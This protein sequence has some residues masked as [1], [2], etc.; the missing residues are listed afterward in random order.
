MISTALSVVNTVL[1]FLSTVATKLGLDLLFV[2][3]LGVEILF[4]LFFI[5][6]SS[7]SY[8]VSLNRALDKL[9]YWL[10]QKKVVN[11]ENIRS[12]NALFKTRAPK[13][14]TYYW[15]QYV[16]F[17]EG[18]PSTYFTADN[19]VDKPVKTSSYA[20]DIK[21]LGIVTCV[22]AVLAT[23]FVLISQSIEASTITGS[24]LVTALLL[25]FVIVLLG[26]IFVLYMR[27]RRNNVIA[28]VYQNVS[29][30]DRFMDNACQDLTAYVDYQI[31]FTPA[32]IQK[33][34][35]VL[36][37]FLDFKAR[38]E[39]EEFS[40]AKE[41]QI[42]HVKYDF[43]KTGVNGKIVLDRAMKETE[44]FLKRRDKLLV[45]IAQLEAELD[46][47][48]KN[49]DNVQIESQTKIQ[50]S[51]E[52]IVRLRQM[53]E[54]T[55]NRIESNYYRKQQTQEAA[56]QEQLEQE[57]E[58]QKAKYLLEKG[59]V[60][61]E[62][63]A[64]KGDL[65]N[66][67]KSVEDAMLAEYTTFFD[68]FCTSAEKVVGKV[69]EEKFHELKQENE[70]DKE[71]ITELELQLKNA[72]QPSPNAQEGTYDENGNYV[73]PNGTYYD[74]DGLF[75]DVQDGT[76]VTSTA[77][78]HYD[79]AGNYI[80][81]N[82]TYYDKSGFFHDTQGNVYSQD[83]KLVIA[84]QKEEVPEQTIDL[85]DFDSFDFMT[86]VGQKEDVYDVAKDI[87]NGLGEGVTVTNSAK[88][89]EEPAEEPAEESKEEKEEVKPVEEEKPQEDKLETVSLDDIE[90]EN[91]I[92]LDDFEKTDFG[93]PEEEQ[94]EEEPEEIE[95][96]EEEPEDEEEEE[97]DFEYEEEKP[98]KRVG[99]PR[100]I[101]SA[102][103]K[104]KKP[105]RPRK[106]K[107]AAPA[108]K[109][110]V[111]RP[112]KVEVAEPPKKRVGRPRKVEAAKVAKKPVGRPK[113]AVAEQ[114]RKVG[115]PRKTEAPK[116]TK[117]PVGRPRKTEVLPEPK[118]G[119][120]RPRKTDSISEINRRLSEEE[121][122]LAQMRRDLNRELELAMNTNGVDAVQSKRN[123]L[124]KEIDKLQREAQNA[125]NGN[126]SE[127]K[128]K[129]IN[130]KLEKILAEI[131]RLG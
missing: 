6:K 39:K 85:N 120:G 114:K 99:R 87:I 117:K 119:R 65:E 92:S 38:K 112:R 37:E 93:E 30:F 72:S 33:G 23:V 111:G 24:A 42:D 21:N 116:V 58:Q 67:R 60:E 123:K 28:A 57:F 81:P 83:G 36:R 97:D 40:R 14:L 53:Q 69:F 70:T 127:E 118:K 90:K 108:K 8:E 103:A 2:I 44:L 128:M 113:K 122:K 101:V 102:P 76:L 80:Y 22:W 25:G 3:G 73:Y 18:K 1:N 17:R 46:S 129:Q 56:K 74:K 4:I 107:P 19:L 7:S 12:L 62:I 47:R 95:E 100:K 110:A 32:E 64:L 86:D 35:P 98:T 5:I 45:Q 11:E 55:T 105:G 115:R 48:K 125:I 88:K 94:E 26:S 16:L 71:Y 13:R 121:A 50:A 10:F 54:E 126:E 89:E 9:N 79:D 15:H 49:F 124:M 41:E 59:E 61:Q 63:N 43:S 68:K 78:G 106:E 84:A 130:S 52:N 20:S 51:K 109:K 131:K 66:Y 29:L 96:V 91:T 82:G 104:A 75:H 34:Q 31:L 77:E 27:S